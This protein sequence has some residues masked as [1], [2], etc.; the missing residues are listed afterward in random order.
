MENES[1]QQDINTLPTFY[2]SVQF[3]P[4]AVRVKIALS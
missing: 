3:I 4:L 2:N 1:Y